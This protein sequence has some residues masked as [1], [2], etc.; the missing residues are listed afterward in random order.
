MTYLYRHALFISRKEPYLDWANGLE[1]GPALTEQLSRKERTVYLAPEVDDEPELS[2]LV[3]EFWESI[4]EEELGA[5]VIAEERWPQPRTR[6]MFDAWFEVELS[7][8]VYD[9]TPE[10]PLTQAQVDA[11][12]LAEALGRCAACGLDVEEDEGRFAGFKL[13]DWRRVAPF[14]GRVL[15]LAVDDDQVVL[16]VVTHDGSEEA[17]AGDDILVRVCS[18]ACEKAVRKTV[19]KALRRL[20]RRPEAGA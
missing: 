17:R 3:D 11:L 2:Q 13:A 18:S 19:P 20:F 9:L 1:E 14:E 6:E 4:F 8:S 12:D 5:W 7:G 10:E 15:P 16:C